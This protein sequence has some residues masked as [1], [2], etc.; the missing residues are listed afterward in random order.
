MIGAAK[1]VPNTG[2]WCVPELQFKGKE[3]AY[4]H[5]LTVPFRPLEVQ[6]DKGI[7]TPALDGNLIIHGDNL[8]A[9]KALLP[10][11][12]GKVDC[13]FIDPPYNTGNDWAYSDNINSPMNREWRDDNPVSRDDGLR[14]DKWLSMMWPRFRLLHQLLSDKGSLWITLDDNEAHGAKLILDEIFGENSFITQVSWQKRTSRENRAVFSPSVDHMLVY[15][16]CLKDTWKLYRNRLIPDDANL[17]NPDNDKRGAYVSSPFSAQGFRKDQVYPITTPTGKVHV[18]PKGR[19]WAA[20]EP[21]FQKFLKDEKVYWPREGDGKPR[22][23]LFPEEL[24]G[25]VPSTLWF[26]REVG[27]TEASKKLLLEDRK[28]VV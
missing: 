28:S 27:D 3:F 17:V 6:A 1:N 23:K 18:P 7:G 14:H 22:I 4:N 26:S 11:H 13:I 2:D 16:K 5:H 24:K 25:L 20:T 21:E 8:H 19:C 15:S 12:A 10:T 9:L